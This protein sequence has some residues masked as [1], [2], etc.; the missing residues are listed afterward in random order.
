MS[1]YLLISGAK[2]RENGFELGEGR[3][4]EQAKLLKLDIESGKVDTILEKSDGGEHYPDEHPNLQYTSAFLDGDILWLPT[5]TEIYKLSY[6]SLQ[7]L[8]V[9][10]EPF[11]H[12]I[13]SVNVF[14]KKVYVTS[15]GLDLVA[16]FDE[17]GELLDMYNTEGKD[18]WHRF[19]K[20]E[21]YRIIHSTRPHDCHPNFVFKWQDEAWVTRCRQQDAIC[22]TDVDK[23]MELTDP[24]NRI[25]VHDGMVFGEFIYF[26]S[27]DG[28]IIVM[29]PKTNKIVEQFNLV[30]ALN[31]G[32]LGWARG[33][34]ISDD[35]IAYVGFSKIRRTKMVEKLAWLALGQINKM[36]YIPASVVAFDLINKKIV[37]QFSIPLEEIDAVYGIELA[38]E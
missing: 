18:L 6:P 30:K 29:D 17:D 9:I 28:M 2:E 20:D 19:S 7:V 15:T 35:G 36:R 21:D 34:S 23:K 5:D 13:H 16:V 26:T 31:K 4:Y 27:V 1:K 14:D 12:N 33:I 22:L 38:N 8:K 37:Q 3:Y 10:S 32:E 24:L 11:F 25:S